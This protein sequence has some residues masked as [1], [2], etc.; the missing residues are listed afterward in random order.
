M[1]KLKVGII[2]CGVI[3]DLNVLGYLNNDD[4]EIISLCDRRLKN[5]KE[6]IQ[7]FDLNSNIRIYKDYKEMLD[8]ERIDLLEILLPHHL[9]HEV[10]LYAAQK[11]LKGISVQK[12][13]ANT[14]KECDEMI[15]VC[16]NNNIKLK[17]FE[18]FTFYP[19]IIKAKQLIE[20]GIIGEVNSIHIKSTRAGKGGWRVPGSASR[21]RYDPKTCGG[22]MDRGSPC[23]FDDG[24]HKFWLALHFIENKIEKVYA[25]IDGDLIDIPA[26]IMWKYKQPENTEFIVP[27]YGN[28]EFNLSPQM[29]LPSP[30]YDIDEFIL[31]TGSTGVMWINQVTAG[32]NVMSDSEIFPPVVVF[33]DGKV[34]SFTDMER[35]WKYGF[36]NSTK[37]FI[38]VIKNDGA[39]LLTGEE[40]RYTI[41]FS[42][43]AIKSS[44]EGR[45]INP[46][47][48]ID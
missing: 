32:G 45:E 5:V 23:V 13:M 20:E 22:G 6:K 31:L 16:K 36:I 17:I 10:T 1:D 28:M 35:D 48:M 47:D 11:N 40:G 25:W 46:D 30:Y 4:A 29:Y 41:Q 44:L 43:A 19:P 12:P 33:R 18:N 27:K 37:H 34:E 26:Y 39:P 15:N 2:G 42:L 7:K 24:F 8:S 3:F 9:H 14:V 38:D 21:W